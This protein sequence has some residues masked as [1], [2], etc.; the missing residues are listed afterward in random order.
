MKK[1]NFLISTVFTIIIASSCTKS[2]T[3]LQS[4]KIEGNV[5]LLEPSGLTA[6]Q[7]NTGTT[8][9]I[10]NTGSSIVASSDKNG[11]FELPSIVIKGTVVVQYAHPGYGTYKQF[12]I[13]S[14]W[15]SLQK[16]LSSLSLAAALTPVSSV[17][18]NSLSGNIE[19]DTLKLKCNV[20]LPTNIGQ[21]YIS[22]FNSKSNSNISLNNFVSTS[23]S[24][25]PVNSGDNSIYICL[26]ENIC[27]TW[28][29]G[30]TINLRAFGGVSNSYFDPQLNM[31]VFP[32][33][34]QNSNLRTLSLIIPQQ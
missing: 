14:A 20:N 10:E 26:C 18:V 12:F 29:P 15:D 21:Q 25:L 23:F 16:G 11:N 3:R 32:S 7:D 1:L 27:N 30:D 9:T 6:L 34:N 2:S 5:I 8:I 4:Q 24:V 17:F 19:N 13:A 31:T 33:L 22:L 28:H